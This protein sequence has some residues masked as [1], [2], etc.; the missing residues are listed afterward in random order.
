[1]TKRYG[2]G[3]MSVVALTV[4][5]VAAGA[6]SAASRSACRS[7]KFPVYFAAGTATLTPSADRV[8]RSA[9]PRMAACRV[10]GIQMTVGA[11]SRQ[12]ELNQRRAEAVSAALVEAGA[13]SDLA[14]VEKRQTPF[15]LFQ[16]RVTVSVRLLAQ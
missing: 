16:R 2:L 9:A 7:F 10:A 8:I 3:C 6:A 5:L 14:Q 13:P 15:R 11:D 1:M 4:T 12:S